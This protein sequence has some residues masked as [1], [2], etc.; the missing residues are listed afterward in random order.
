LGCSQV[1]LPII[2]IVSLNKIIRSLCWFSEAPDSL[3]LEELDDL[4]AELVEKG[5]EV[6]TR[7]VCFKE[8]D[9][10]ALSSWGVDEPLYVSV[11]S[12]DSESARGLHGDFLRIP[13]LAFNLDLTSGVRAAD[14]EI[15]LRTV[16]DEPAKTFYFAYTFHN[17]PSSP[18]FPSATFEQP[19]FS[20][21]FQAT[22]LAEGCR[23]LEEWIAKMKT[24]WAEII[25]LFQAHPAFLGIDSSIAPLFEG[26]SSLIHFVKRVCG[27]FSRAAT[28]DI[29]LSLTRFLTDGNPKP[30]GLCGLMLPC[31][32]D[33]ELA[34]EYEAGHFS[35]ERNLFLALHSGLGLDAYP[36]GTDEDPDKILNVLRLLCGLSNKY[37][38]PLSA[39][40]VSDGRARIGDRTE[41]RNPYLKDVRVRPL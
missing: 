13:N 18:F 15:L 12:L 27:S 17:R 8:A 22:D 38:K 23:T 24:V 5:F 20:V 7:R 40:F 1:K 4:S 37:K 29:F 11:G 35:I 32:E 2:D 14:V 10:K 3:V 34:A 6:Q 21:G 33:F 26:R 25:E 16:R 36:I 31:L 39:R 41:F 9:I 28:T 19:G 30:A